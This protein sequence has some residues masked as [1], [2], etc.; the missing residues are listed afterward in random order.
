MST[1]YKGKIARGIW[2]TE[3]FLNL[4]KEQDPNFN[5]S[6]YVDQQLQSDFDSIEYK[7]DIFLSKREN[8]P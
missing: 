1:R 6:H 7:V 8:K 3:K 4:A 2:I 5:L